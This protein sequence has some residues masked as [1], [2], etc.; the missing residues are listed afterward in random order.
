MKKENEGIINKLI[1][2]VIIIF[3]NKIRKR[4]IRKEI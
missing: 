1:Y 3:D 2:K 4:N